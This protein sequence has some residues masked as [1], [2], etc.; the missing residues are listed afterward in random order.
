MFADYSNTGSD[1]G[2]IKISSTFNNSSYYVWLDTSTG[3]DNLGVEKDNTDFVDGTS[4]QVKIEL[5]LGAD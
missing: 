3:T 4:I 5:S 1:G 2:N